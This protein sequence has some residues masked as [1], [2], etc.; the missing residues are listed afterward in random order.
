[1]PPHSQHAQA[2][3]V[4]ALLEPQDDLSRHVVS[5]LD[6]RAKGRLAQTCTGV[7]SILK[8]IKPD[9]YLDKPLTLKWLKTLARKWTIKG[10]VCKGNRWTKLDA[11]VTACP[12]LEK[13]ELVGCDHITSVASL[14]SSLTHLVVS[15]CV[16]ISSVA[17]LPS[18]L[19]SLVLRGCS[20]ITSVDSLPSS[21]TRLELRGCV[22]IPSV[23]SLPSSLTHLE[24]RGCG[25]ITSVDSLPNSLTRLEVSYC[26]QITPVDSLPS[27]LTRLEL[28]GCGGVTDL[29][30]AAVAIGL[31]PE[32]AGDDSVWI[33]PKRL[34]LLP[35]ASGGA[36]LRKRLF[37]PGDALGGSSGSGGS[38][39]ASAFNLGN[40]V[41]E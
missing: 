5:H 37:C 30:H 11:V 1:M 21:L 25:H 19:T 6:S 10:V 18:S 20:D 9:V 40:A 8:S 38:S 23:A 16:R 41:Q 12:Y 2:A 3:L 34:V 32:T 27:S 35:D 36:A 4:T 15:D 24:L 28:R 22:C 31:Q 7:N 39:G 33:R 29:V 17:S 26:D 14:P 13:L